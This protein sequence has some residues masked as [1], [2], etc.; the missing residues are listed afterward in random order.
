MK[1]FFAVLLILAL[2]LGF[3]VPALA[4]S[5]VRSPQKLTVDG[6]SVECDKYN[7]D[8]SNYFKLRDL[9]YVLNGTGSQFDVGWDEANKVVSVTTDHAYTTPNGTELEIGADKSGTAVVSPQTIMINGEVRTDLTVYNIGGSNF[10]K[11][12]ELGDALGFDVDYI[13]ETNTATVESWAEEIEVRDLCAIS[14]KITEESGAVYNYSFSLPQITGAN[15]ADILEINA[16]MRQLYDELVR[17]TLDYLEES[18]YLMRYCVS[19]LHGMKNGVH[20]LLITADSDWGDNQYWCCS[21]DEAGNMVE[22]EAVLQAVGMT[23][24]TFVSSARDYLT[25]HTDLSE[26]FIDDGEDYGWR[27]LQAQTVSDDNCN[28]EMPMAILPNGNLCFI[29]TVYT[30]AGAGVYETALEFA[31]TGE[32]QYANVGSILLNR[33]TGTYLVEQPEPD[34]D[35]ESFA[36]AYYLEIFTVGDALTAEVTAFDREYGSVYYYYGADIIPE[37]PSALLRAD[38]S[39]LR[40]RVLSW[41]PDVFGSSYY[42][43][44]GV[45][46]LT[47][48]RD[49]VTFSDF[50]GGTPF[51]GIDFTADTCY[52]DQVSLDSEMP[53]KD[54]QKFDYDAAADAGIAGVWGGGYYDINTWKPHS[55]TLEMSNWGDMKLRDC[56]DGEIPRVLEG[57]Y[58]IAKEGDDFAPAGAVV[59]TLAARGGYKM[60]Q[61]GW[62]TMEIDADGLLQITESEEGYSPLLK[63]SPYAA[64]ELTRIPT[65][66]ES[67]QP[68]IRKLAEGE[69]VSVD[70]YAD[71]TPEKLSY[72]LTQEENYGPITAISF[73]LNGAEY[74]ETDQW[75]NDADVYLVT[76]GLSGAVYFYVDQYMDNDNRYMQIF[77]ASADG[78]RRVGDYGGGFAASPT[79]AE[80]LLLYDTFQF[81]STMEAARS[82]RVGTSGLPEATEPFFYALGDLTLTAKQDIDFCWIVTSDSGELMD[83]M[84]LPAGTQGK[85]LRTDGSEFWDLLLADGS[86]VRVFVDADSW[87]QTV[88]GVNIGE[89]FDGVGFAG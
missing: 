7:I 4:A 42:G 6:K 44:P 48:G 66:R 41:C 23:P 86:C 31:G 73:F 64:A 45:Y 70:I 72:A 32:I 89:C 12:R 30:P 81:L 62:C 46:T 55:V 22:N 57:Q 38:V 8:G 36:P 13:K 56:V 39:S 47:V 53:E 75:Y 2:L 26:Y 68:Q 1:K 79:S 9:A 87:P 49:F 67:V 76:P 3:G 50:E 83:T 60:P 35:D 63:H 10:F 77:R 82:Y 20:S 52:S 69:T 21:F 5:V 88:G 71:G 54:Y 17:H 58:Y 37:D 84:T 18:G 28:A 33:L 25:E 16:E 80:S 78:V 61:T 14:G 40:V 51:V 11:L 59:Y 19:Y 34:E 29:A 27:A 24:E 43:E 85:L 74:T 15:T 65:R